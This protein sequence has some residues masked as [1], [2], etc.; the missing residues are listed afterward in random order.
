MLLITCPYCGV[1]AEEAELQARGEV[2][3]KRFGPC[4]SDEDFTGYLFDREDPKGMYFQNSSVSARDSWLK[5]TPA[6][7]HSTSGS[8]PAPALS[9][10][11]PPYAAHTH[12]HRAALSLCG[13]RRSPEPKHPP[14][15]R[16]IRI[17]TI[18]Y[19]LCAARGAR[20][21]PGTL[22]RL[23]S[24]FPTKR[25]DL[26]QSDPFQT[27]SHRPTQQSAHRPGNLLPTRLRGT[28][29]RP[30]S[31]APQQKEWSTWVRHPSGLQ[32]QPWRSWRWASC[33]SCRAVAATYPT[34][35]R[36]TAARRLM[37]SS[38]PCQPTQAPTAPAADTQTHVRGG[39]TCFS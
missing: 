1:Q 19:G 13:A 17:P 25:A 8:D 24:S 36:S 2:H 37:K 9:H 14:A 20:N 38:R 31:Y 5:A 21:Q 39:A 27:C 11:R 3:L 15:A 32:L 12:A 22:M 33:C 18:P 26:R 35:T 4:S 34:P 6:I 30:T 23:T 7:T 16:Q 28:A 29:K 10:G